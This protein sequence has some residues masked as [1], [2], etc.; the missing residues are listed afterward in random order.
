VDRGNASSLVRRGRGV[1]RLARLTVKRGT[2][3]SLLAHLTVKRGTGG[4]FLT[5]SP[6][7]GRSRNREFAALTCEGGPPGFSPPSLFGEGKLSA[8][9]DVMT[10]EV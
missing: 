1:S 9:S 2:G 5:P 8:N 7:E 10:G 3:K 4:S 6:G